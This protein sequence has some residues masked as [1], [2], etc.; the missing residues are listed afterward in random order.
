MTS[1][2][3]VVAQREKNKMMLT[4]LILFSTSKIYSFSQELSIFSMNTL[5]AEDTFASDYGAQ[6]E[7]IR[8]HNLE[9]DNF[10]TEEAKATLLSERYQRLNIFLN[11][12][13][14]YH[15]IIVLQEVDLANVQGGEYLLKYFKPEMGSWAISCASSSDSEQEL[16]LY[17]TTHITASN[18]S[19]F[20]SGG[21]LGCSTTFEFFN[22][23]EKVTIFSIHISAS[24][25]RNPDLVESTLNVLFSLMP[26]VGSVVICGDFNAHLPDLLESIIQVDTEGH[27]WTIATATNS[28]ETP[29]RYHFTSQNEHNF[30]A[31]Y[32]GCLLRDYREPSEVRIYE[33][34]FM[35]KYLGGEDYGYGNSSFSY[36]GGDF[37]VIDGDLLLLSAPFDSTGSNFANVSLS[38]H[39]AVGVSFTLDRENRWN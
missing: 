30:I 8:L 5:C 4:Y 24:A 33:H 16:I 11:E 34:G 38:D 10:S 35:P 13:R 17:D 3:R 1:S 2:R 21:I 23:E 7:I 29:D 25:I 12:Q 20:N 32:D 27:Q 18:I 31:A 26:A 39:L 37:P 9:E 6:A 19:T 36:S 28:T 22:I 14:L 15:E